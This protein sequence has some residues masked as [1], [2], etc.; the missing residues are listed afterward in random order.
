[1][2]SQPRRREGD[3]ET[4][5]RRA[6]ERE[7]QRV[8]ER[9]APT[10]GLAKEDVQ[11]LI[12]EALTYQKLPLEDPARAKRL[13]NAQ[14]FESPFSKEIEKADPLQR[15][16][17]PKLRIYNGTSDPVDHVQHFQH[18][19]ALWVGNEPLMSKVFP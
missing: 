4:Q 1:M 17:I 3:V 5:T 8:L 16:Y 15:F 14:N 2:S 13:R 10:K 19:M 18:F 9:K 12:E 6:K 11:A 7:S